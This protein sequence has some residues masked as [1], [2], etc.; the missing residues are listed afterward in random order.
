MTATTALPT[1]PLA[2]F[3]LGFLTPFLMTGDIT[4]PTLAR[5]AAQQA[6]DD[7][8]AQGRSDPISIARTLTFTLAAL[9]N[10][11]LSRQS[12]VSASMRLRLRANA[13]ALNRS[14]G[15][16]AEPPARRLDAP[17]RADTKETNPTE[18]AATAAARIPVSAPGS[19]PAA[20]S[21]PAAAT[22]AQPDRRLEWASA[23]R[24]EAALLRN[25]RFDTSP[26]RRT[27]NRF[28]VDVLTGAAADLTQPAGSGCRP[29]LSKAEL[30]RTTLMSAD[31]ARSPYIAAK[32]SR[33]RS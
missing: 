4:D 16:V 21:M 22:I 18:D 5:A 28:W 27:S 26:A 11:R 3:L 6:I 23:M 14:A 7:C 20:P 10:L 33:G 12:D 8:R 32:A 25:S 15:N 2:E 31:P 19:Q 24:T 9:D 17:A 29:G 13:N 30:L 1:N